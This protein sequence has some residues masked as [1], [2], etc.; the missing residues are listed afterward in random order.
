MAETK[1]ILYIIYFMRVFYVNI[2]EH[3]IISYL[4]VCSHSDNLHQWYN[5]SQHYATFVLLFF[6]IFCWH[7][8]NWREKK[9]YERRCHTKM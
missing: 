7:F 6:V 2:A 9:P 1:K 4:L 5:V 3:S 8:K